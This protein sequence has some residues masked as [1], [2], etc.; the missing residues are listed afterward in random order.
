MPF[1]TRDTADA[2]RPRTSWGVYGVTVITAIGGFLFGYDTGV[3][4]S[5]LPHISDE[6]GLSSFTSG[7]VTSA[8]LVG[9]MIGAFGVGPLSDRFGRKRLLM[10]AAAV[11]VLGSVGAAASPN[12]LL[13][14]GARG[15]LGVAVGAASSLVPVFIAE[16]APPHLR[17]RL[18]SM[19]QLLITIGIVGAYATGYAFED[20]GNWRAM[21]GV[22][23]IPALVLL[24]GMALLPETP[25]W[26]VN[27]GRTDEARR[28]LARLRRDTDLDTELEEIRAVRE[29]H[30]AGLSA[31]R[32]GWVRPALVAGIGLQIFGQ[33]SGVNT[34]IYYAPTIFEKAGIGSSGAV[35]ATVG[36]GIVNVVC[37]II[38][39]S[40]IDRI[41][42]RKLLI[43][44]AGVMTVSL[45][46]LALAL[47]VGGGAAIGYVAVT[48][49]AI[50]IAAFAVAFGVVIFVLPS[51]LY[52]QEIRGTAMSVTLF[53]NWTVN[54]VVSLTFLT[55]MDALGV[56]PTFWLYTAICAL[57]VV[58]A[59]RCVP[60]TKGRSLE[61]IEQELRSAADEK[62]G[63]DTGDTATAEATRHRVGAS[64]DQPE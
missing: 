47:G 3:I 35:L 58:F 28:V 56:S 53:S 54:F 44:G 10:V 12:A 1:P 61:E 13:L 7:V 20:E 45:G 31:L 49:L 42:R 17:G 25:R 32:R 26:L 43:S 2:A 51:E 18:V 52:P 9:A 40:L 48:C 23:V 59:V 41:G 46:I 38:G 15:L 62:A 8:I 19:N 5:A 4:A 27:K 55:L 6:F 21:F 64:S 33:A 37:T 22:G 16:A 63:T 50:Y 24:I 11:F 60:E 57:A 30:R 29:P 34:V 36:V 14:I 39:M